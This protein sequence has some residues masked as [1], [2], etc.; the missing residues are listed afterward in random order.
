M[1][2]Q[3]GKMD[4]FDVVGRGDV[5]GLKASTWTAAELN[6]RNEAGLTP[7]MLTAINGDYKMAEALKALG[8]DKDEVDEQGRKAVDL[9]AIY[10]HPKV[11]V[12]LIEGGC[13]G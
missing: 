2:S 4:I 7:L 10:G 5:K 1:K 9:A 6:G 13:G 12:Y 8:A 11:I 3:E